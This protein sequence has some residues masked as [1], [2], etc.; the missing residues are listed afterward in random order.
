MFRKS[1]LKNYKYW[2]NNTCTISLSILMIT[3]T[4]FQLAWHD[5]TIVLKN[6]FWSR[7][8]SQYKPPIPIQHIWVKKHLVV[9]FRENIGLLS[10][11]PHLSRVDTYQPTIAIFLYI[12]LINGVLPLEPKNNTLERRKIHFNDLLCL[13]DVT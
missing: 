5:N 10:F 4:I 7:V 9:V 8:M 2:W 11:I 3:L 12:I 13:C 6:M 1:H